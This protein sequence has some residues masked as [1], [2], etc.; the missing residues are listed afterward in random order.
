[1]AGEIPVGKTGRI[2]EGKRFV[3]RFVRVEDDGDGNY[4]VITSPKRNFEHGEL[5]DDV[6]DDWV[7]NENE[8]SL[9]EYFVAL[10][11]VVEWLD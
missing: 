3:G 6:W 5:D 10:G 9:D 4:L 7:Q 2:T 8:S 11:Y 1:M